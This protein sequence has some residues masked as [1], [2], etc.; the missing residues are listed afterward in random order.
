MP[1][2]FSSSW[3][4]YVAVALM[5]LIKSWLIHNKPIHLPAS[6]FD[7]TFFPKLYVLQ[8][9]CNSSWQCEI[10][11]YPHGYEKASTS[12]IMNM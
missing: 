4:I 12:K 11:L 3:F 9:A 8:G 6:L 7:D 5:G 1:Q 10:F 2:L